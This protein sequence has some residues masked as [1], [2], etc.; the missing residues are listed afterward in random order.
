MKK[1]PFWNHN[2]VYYDWVNKKIGKRIKILDVGCGD[3]ALVKYLS[4]SEREIVVI[5]PFE[6]NIQKA[7]QES[8]PEWKIRY[9]CCSFE[10]YNGEEESFDA[11]IFVASLHHMNMEF[12][13]N[14]ARKMLREKG[15]L[16][17]V[18]LDKPT[19]LS[20]WFTEGIRF[21]PCWI[22]STLRQTKSSEE[23]GLPTSY[24][25]PARS[26]VWK[27]ARELPDSKLQIGLYYRYL[28]SWVK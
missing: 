10:S 21:I 12:A 4:N 19:T 14:K 23:L 2:S 6:K 20:D 3:G 16:I 24:D 17:V 27:V 9:E 8:E 13:I 22:I 1:L 25:F 18:G 15:I 5:D 28:L 7:Q 11:I 26:E